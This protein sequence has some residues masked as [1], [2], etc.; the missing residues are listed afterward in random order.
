MAPNTT[1]PT[2][3]ISEQFQKLDLK[4]LAREKGAYQVYPKIHYPP[5]EAFEH[6]D[7]GKRADPKKAS[8]YDNATKIFDMTPVLGTT[9]E[10]LQLSQLTD[11]QKSDLALLAAERGVV[12]FPNQDIDPYQG[13]EFGKYFGRL[14]IHNTTGHP[15]NLPEVTSIFHDETNPQVVKYLEAR[16]AD[17]AWH[18]DITYENQPAGLTFLKIDTL[19]PMGGDTLWASAYEAYDR[20][21]PAMQ[22]FVEG[23]EAV[24]D[25]QIHQDRSRRAGTFIRRDFVE[26]IH[27]VVRTHPLTG[28]KGLFVQPGFTKRIVGLSNKESRLMLDFLF[29]HVSGGHD[30]QLRF[31]WTEDTVAVWDNRAT[32]HC[33]IFDYF[34]AKLG[35]RH[36]WRVTP[37]AE[38]PY[39]DPNS[40]SRRQDLAEKAALATSTK[41]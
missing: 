29:K 8:L 40:K 30:F 38:K 34:T 35:R 11:Q 3:T 18:S 1:T 27:P 28:W 37:T 24:H 14:H 7:P 6:D 23:L 26:S 16:S 33:A 22:K 41:E 5:L 36:G 13:V 20:L 2:E 4:A 39:F 12:F 10:G 9:I 25:G 21:S 17:E 31:K 32:F 15:E 19:P